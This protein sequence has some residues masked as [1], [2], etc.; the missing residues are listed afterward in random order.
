M[1]NRDIVNVICIL[2]T[3]NIISKYKF[4]T[5]KKYKFCF[6]SENGDEYFMFFDNVE[7][8]FGFMKDFFDEHFISIEEYRNIK[9]EQLCHSTI[10]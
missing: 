7:H 9:L 1:K 6:C 2:E 5:N 3:K 10:Q 4:E 8:N